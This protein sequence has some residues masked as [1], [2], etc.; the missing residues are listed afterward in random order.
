MCSLCVRKPRSTKANR[1]A[2]EVRD[3]RLGLEIGHPGFADKIVGM[4]SAR[5]LAVS[6]CIL[7]T[8]EAA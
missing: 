7:S 5:S 6:G 1:L 8:F 2:A 4:E 3:A